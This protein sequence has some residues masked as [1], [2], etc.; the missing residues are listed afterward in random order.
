[1][2]SSDR[3]IYFTP[4]EVNFLFPAPLGR[5]SLLI[6][7]IA[8]SV[9]IG[10]PSCL[11]LS[12]ITYGYSRS[13]L[14]AFLGM[15]LIVMFMQMFGMALNLVAVTVG[16]GYLRTAR[17]AAAGSGRA[18]VGRGRHPRA[19]RRPGER[20]ADPL[21]AAGQHHAGMEDDHPA[22]DAV[23]PG[24]H[25]PAG[26]GRTWPATRHSACSSMASCCASCSYWTRSTW[27]RPRRRRPRLRP[28]APHPHGDRRDDGAAAGC[29]SRC[30]CRRRWAVSVPGAGGS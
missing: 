19:R 22:A 5:R 25:G 15:L 23:L 3:G 14:N 12:V 10:V 28:H 30:H 11:I 20:R 29:A 16:R 17:A 9:I 7:K 27:R 2:M 18:G 1:M 26:P 4:A 13:F 24:L 6:F 21:V 8:S